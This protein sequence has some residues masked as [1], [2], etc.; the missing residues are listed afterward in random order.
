[1]IPA[2]CIKEK[3]MQVVELSSLPTDPNRWNSFKF[4]SNT[5]SWGQYWYVRVTKNT[6]EDWGYLLMARTETEWWSNFLSTIGESADL[7]DFKMCTSFEEAAKWT[8]WST[9]VPEDWKCLYEN[10][11]QLRYVYVF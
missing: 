3:L 6:L 1:M 11:W 8:S 2:S 10:K 7:K 5:I 4:W 9:S